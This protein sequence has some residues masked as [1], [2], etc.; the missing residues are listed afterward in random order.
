MDLVEWSRKRS[1]LR[2]GF[3]ICLEGL[4]KAT[5]YPVNVSGVGAAICSRYL[6]KYE[7][8]LPITRRRS[9]SISR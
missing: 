9:V 4:S 6:L 5:K 2:Y 1:N 8:G 3:G 7:A